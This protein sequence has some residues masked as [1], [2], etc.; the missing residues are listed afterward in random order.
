MTA[1]SETGTEL[2][3]TGILLGTTPSQT[4]SSS[5]TTTKYCADQNGMSTPLII[6]SNQVTSNQNLTS[7]TPSDASIN[8][9]ESKPGFTFPNTNAFVNI[10][11]QKPA[12]IA[13]V[14]IAS[15][16]PYQPT[17][18]LHFLLIIVYQNGSTVELS[19]V[20]PSGDS[21]SPTSPAIVNGYVLP[22]SRDPQVELSSSTELPKGTVLMIVLGA[23]NDMLAP[24]R[25]SDYFRPSEL[26]T[27]K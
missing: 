25:V 17:N 21:T 10:T 9:T 14:Y 1:A 7:T 11:L 12:T 2:T 24:S 26:M 8:P 18:V 6:Q 22:S 23:T 15:T 5:S 27:Q 19:S 3:V 20:V 4:T 13:L 16:R